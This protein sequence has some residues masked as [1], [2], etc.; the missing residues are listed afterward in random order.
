M[1]TGEGGGFTIDRKVGQPSDLTE[2]FEPVANHFLLLDLILI[3]FDAISF[4][5]E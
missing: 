3:N 1:K 2:F 5:V 4:I